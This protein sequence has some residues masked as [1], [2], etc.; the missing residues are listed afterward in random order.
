VGDYGNASDAYQQSSNMAPTMN[1]LMA[2]AR[3]TLLE[4][5]V[6]G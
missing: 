1:P 3:A 4:N 2:R 6:S 5:V